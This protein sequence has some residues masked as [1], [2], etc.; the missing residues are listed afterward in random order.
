MGMG[1]II[2]IQRYDFCGVNGW[3]MV[4]TDGYD[5]GWDGMR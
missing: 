3:P 5:L 1:I 2:S 4:E